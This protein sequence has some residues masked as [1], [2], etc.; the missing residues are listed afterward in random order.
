MKKLDFLL[1]DERINTSSRILEDFCFQNIKETIFP[2]EDELY[3][4]F[5]D[6]LMHP[7][8]DIN[9]LQKRQLIFSDFCEYSHLTEQIYSICSK[10]E[11]FKIYTQVSLYRSMSP[12]ERL[13]NYIEQTIPL[14]IEMDNLALLFKHKS[15]KSEILRKLKFE[16]V[17]PLIEEIRALGKVI[18]TQ[19]Y[20]LKVNFSEGFK[21]RTAEIVNTEKVSIQFKTKDSKNPVKYDENNIYFYGFSMTGFVAEE[22]YKTSIQ[23]LCSIVSQINS[24]ILEIFRELKKAAGFFIAAMKIMYYLDT[25]RFPYCIPELSDDISFGIEAKGLYDLSL[26]AYEHEGNITVNSFDCTESNILIVTG[27]N[28]G[29]KTTFLRSVGIAQLFAQAGLFVPA[30]HYKCSCFCGILTHFP[31]EEDSKMDFGK[32]ADELTRLRKDF[33]IITR[34]GLALFNESFSTTT[35]REGAEIAVDVLRALSQTDATVIFVTHLYELAANID[36]LNSCLCNGIKA[37]SMV[38]EYKENGTRTYK[39]IKGQPIED[40]HA[41]ELF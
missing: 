18:N 14:I 6:V 19:C 25:I 3:N 26:T 16:S 7:S 29:G 24:A 32:L 10:A 33:P 17:T 30:E 4:N 9:T 21:L 36:K 22:L 34:G 28:S 11:D 38:T 27:L 13:K 31:T 1:L 5:C 15:F 35:T 40:L 41:T 20:E 37:V 39:I 23:N 2:G 8:Y 12:Q